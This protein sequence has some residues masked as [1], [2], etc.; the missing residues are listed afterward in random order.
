MSDSVKTFLGRGAECKESPCT[1]AQ[2]SARPSVPAFLLRPPRFFA[3]FFVPN[4]AL[5]LRIVTRSNLSPAWMSTTLFRLH[6]R[7]YSDTHAAAVSGYSRM[8]FP[9]LHT[10][11]GINTPDGVDLHKTT[12][13]P[14][15][16]SSSFPG[17]PSRAYASREKA[18]VISCYGTSAFFSSGFRPFLFPHS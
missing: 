4:Y 14:F 15:M 1:R 9:D 17:Q 11:H 10:G 8:I 3:S 18:L 12:A 16:K 2:V 7:Q 5:T 6:F 13:L